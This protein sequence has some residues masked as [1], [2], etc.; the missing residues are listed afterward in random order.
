[1][2]ICAPQLGQKAALWG[3]ENLSAWLADERGEILAR[4]GSMRAGFARLADWTLV[5]CGA[6]FAYVAHPFD[7][8][9]DRV[10]RALV[11]RA[12]IL[13]L[14]G[15][16]FGPRADQGGSGRAERTLRVA[17]ANVDAAGIADL[18]R[19]LDDAAASGLEA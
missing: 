11:E 18:F 14:P 13:T 2:A 6:Y 10:A 3:M 5:G 19:R 15:T 1:M 4:G 8:P 17:Y 16:M 7:A 12:G 9:S